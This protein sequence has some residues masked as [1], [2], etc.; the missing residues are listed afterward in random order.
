ML[1]RADAVPQHSLGLRPRSCLSA[2]R[3]KSEVR[4]SQLIL[5][6]SAKR[7]TI[8][9]AVTGAPQS[10]CHPQGYDSVDTS[11]MRS[12]Q[13]FEICCD[14]FK[15]A[16][17]GVAVCQARH[18]SRTLNSLLQDHNPSHVPCLEFGNERL[19]CCATH[20]DASQCASMNL[21]P[22]PLSNGVQ[23]SEAHHLP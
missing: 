8:E 2:G 22:V 13:R 17:A 21:M 7:P 10:G 1:P 11:I 14:N 18:T 4:P 16:T 12:K 5:T 20:H 6:G 23:H 9:Q 15:H 3:G 19:T